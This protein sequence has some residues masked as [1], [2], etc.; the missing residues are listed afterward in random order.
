MLLGLTG[1]GAL[2]LFSE[3]FHVLPE[4]CNLTLHLSACVRHGKHYVDL[5]GEI[6]WIKD[7]IIR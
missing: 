3:Q 6:Y 2:Q 5:S 4:A 1:G 7:I